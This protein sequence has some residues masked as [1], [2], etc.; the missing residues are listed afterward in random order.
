[1]ADFPRCAAQYLCSPPPSCPLLSTA[2]AS[3]SPPS[4]RFLSALIS[5][6]ALC[7][8]L[9][10]CSRRHLVAYSLLPSCRLLSAVI[11]S[12][13]LH[14][15]HPPSCRLRCSKSLLLTQVARA[16][17][18]PSRALSVG[19]WGCPCKVR[20]TNPHNLLTPPGLTF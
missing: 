4:R 10:A 13:A 20:P 11:S 5:S 6:L 16:S 17:S 9:I 7:R 3:F 2:V 18:R 12:L 15:C 1:M 14:L 19:H 8:H